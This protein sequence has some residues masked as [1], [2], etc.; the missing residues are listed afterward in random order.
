RHRRRRR[1]GRR[2]PR[3]RSRLRHRVAGAPPRGRAARRVDRRH[4]HFAGQHRGGAASERR[5]RRE[6]AVRGGGLPSLRGGSVRCGGQRR[7]AAPGRRRHFCAGREAGEG[8]S[9][10]RRVRV[11]HAVRVCVQH[12]VRRRT[13]AAAVDS[14]ELDR[15]AHFSDRAC[16]PRPP[17]GRREPPRARRLHVSRAEAGDERSS[18]GCV[19]VGGAPPDRRV[20]GEEH[21]P[22]AV[23]AS[24]DGIRARRSRAMTR[25]A[26]SAAIVIVVLVYLHNALPHLTTLPRANVDEPW[27]MERG[28]QIMRTGVPS[29][30]MLRLD[31]AYLLQVGYGYLLAGWMSL[32]GVGLFQARLLSVCLGLGIVAMVAAIGRRSVDEIVGVA[33]AL[34]LAT[35]SNFLGGVRDARTDIPSAFFVAA[36]FA[37]YVRGRRTSRTAWFA[38]AGASLGLAVLCHGNAFWAGIV[39]LAWYLFDYRGDALRRPFGYAVVAGWAITFGPY[40]AMVVARWHDVQVQIGNFAADRVPGWKPS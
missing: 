11:R 33:A 3:A 27:L 4:R 9:A 39:L 12:R 13:A 1:A 34:F 38:A 28:Y 16:A 30:P 26:W 7:R 20:R 22:V 31:T 14:R 35:D 21:E 5:R 29:Q 8:R 32:F 37:A 6:G 17:D 36:A 23:E 25:R 15:R 10:R 2:D 24:R 40:L 18:D 19:R